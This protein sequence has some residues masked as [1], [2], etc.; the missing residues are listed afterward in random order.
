METAESLLF[1]PSLFPTLHNLF[2]GSLCDCSPCCLA[3]AI[4]K[5]CVP[6]ILQIWYPHGTNIHKFRSCSTRKKWDVAGE[7]NHMTHRVTHF[8]GYSWFYQSPTSMQWHFSKKCSKSRSNI[9]NNNTRIPGWGTCFI[10][11]RLFE[12]SL[13]N[14]SEITSQT[15]KGTIK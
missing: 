8:R 4:L 3:I 14:S 1:T 11:K 10:L 9:N 12:S 6:K 5:P 15:K 2:C 13:S 7:V